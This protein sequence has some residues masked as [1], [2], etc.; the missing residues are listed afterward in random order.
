MKTEKIIWGLIF[1]FVGTV[2]MLDN[3]NVINF[4]WGSVWRFWPI[5]FILIGANMLLSR[6]ANNTT[7]PIAAATITVLVLVFIGYQGSI[8]REDRG[9]LHFKFNESRRDKNVNWSN[10]SVFTEPY[11]GSKS[12]TLNIQGS[13]TGYELKDTTSMLFQ[14][15]V[16]ESTG[17]YSLEKTVL[18][19]VDVLNFRK[20]DKNGR[21]L[22]MDDIETND[23]R[24]RL[25]SN[26]IWD[27]TVEMGAGETNF[28]LENFKVRNLRFEG[29]AAS[30]QAKVG[31]KLPL[32]EITV[33]TGV[34]S[35]EIEVPKESG[36]RIVVDSGLSSK[37]FSGF[38]K[39]ADG[40]YKSSNYDSAANKVNIN[41]KGGLSSFEVRKY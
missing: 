9:W 15:D 3:F 20:R 1:I 35:V 34:A 4:Y 8:P 12:A 19:S 21:G 23:T 2:F 22:K 31:T 10:A 27:I 26:P 28:N 7:G 41:L 25:N 32:T 38:S 16:N 37:D 36:T 39:Q 6:F 14:A 11:T 33:E 29:G 5:I 17:G 40:T 18:D 13:A 30:F 24:L